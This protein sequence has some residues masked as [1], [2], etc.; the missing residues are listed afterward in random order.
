M[1]EHNYQQAI[2]EA[3]KTE[4]YK[5]LHKPYKHLEGYVNFSEIAAQLAL[6]ISGAEK[7]SPKTWMQDLAWAASIISAKIIEECPCPVYWLDKNLMT[8][9]LATDLPQHVCDI[10]KVV[11]HCI[12]LLPQIL[13]NPDGQYI[14]WLFIHH[15]DAGWHLP[16]MKIG[17][18]TIKLEPMQAN[19]VR[20]ITMLSDGTS[21]SSTFELMID[22]EGLP[23]KGDFDINA[24]VELF[25]SNSD[26]NTETQFSNAVD[27]LVLQILL[28]LQI[29]PDAL[30]EEPLPP[31]TKGIGFSRNLPKYLNPIWIGKGYRAPHE[32]HT[33]TGTH[34][35]PAIHWRRGHYR[36]VPV[37]VGRSDRKWVWI[38]PVLVNAD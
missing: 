34:A 29:K 20:W 22:E 15:L 14:R 1:L 5:Q 24:T 18:Q 30:T 9:L 35:S 33:P 37:G 4:H 25:G 11:P 38:E 10:K 31:V 32:R 17:D 21:Y 6:I 19:S 26:I 8:S 3:K 2:R 16:D 27:K 36:R 7:V 23:I 12:V 28:Y 13:K